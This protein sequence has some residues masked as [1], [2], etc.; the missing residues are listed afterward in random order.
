MAMPDLSPHERAW[1]TSGI[2]LLG[3][4]VAAQIVLL[5]C[6]R[7]TVYPELVVYP[8]LTASG[9]L[10]YREILDQ[11]FPGLLF[12]PV[13]FHTLG[14]RDAASFHVLLVMVAALQSVLTYVVARRLASNTVALVAAAA[15]ALLQPVFEGDQLWL[16][17]FL[18]LFTLPALL[19]LLDARWILAGLLLGLGV[20]F[21][22]TLVPLVAFAGLVVLYEAGWRNVLRFA[23]GA[24]LPATLLLLYLHRVGVLADFWFWT[25]TFNLS[26]YARGGTLAPRLGD[27]VRIALPIALLLPATVLAPARWRPR[28]I[29]LWAC[30]TVVGGLGRFG[31]IHLQPAVP[32]L[33]ILVAMLL[34]E[35]SRRRATVALVAVLLLT[36]VWLGEFYGRRA[37]WGDDPTQ[38]ERRASLESLIRER[39]RPSDEIF[40]LGVTSELYAA[41]GTLPPGRVFVFP[42]PWFLDVAGDRVLAALR[43]STSRLALI[44][45]E[46]GI[47]GRRLQDYA[48]PLI[49]EVRTHGVLR[50]RIGSIEVYE[51]RR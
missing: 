40:L 51:P 10:P 34:M 47:D 22:Q 49:D 46:G 17:V 43:G 9:L 31:L 48:R 1:S 2:A 8:Y 35:L 20:V 4:I 19:L 13:N 36:T 45:P 32:Y 11:H 6:L 38:T 29:V 21:K 30:S 7:I 33:A 5:R 3:A 12:L 44:D 23:A 14:I 50:S 25:V 15:Y 18:P 39:A 41:T 26:T 28:L 42:F 24:L 37:R 27:V 16:D